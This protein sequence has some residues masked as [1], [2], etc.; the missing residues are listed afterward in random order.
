MTDTC[1]LCGR[2]LG[3]RREK[4]H[5]VPRARGGRV[6]VD[7]HPICHR[8]IH[9]TLDDRELDGPLATVD[10]LRYHPEVSR[11]VAWIAD[12]HPDF[13]KPTATARRRRA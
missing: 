5:L 8:K 12:K 9:T 13:Y 3:V 10:G 2:P 7:L 11:F 6:T 4:Q 1:Q